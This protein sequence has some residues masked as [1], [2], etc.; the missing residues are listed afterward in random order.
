MLLLALLPGLVAC[1]PKPDTNGVCDGSDFVSADG[2]S[3]TCGDDEVCLDDAGCAACTP[4]LTS[5]YAGASPMVLETAPPGS[6]PGI[7][8]SR[9]VIIAT[10]DNIGG[11]ALAFDGPAE[12]LD[13]DGVVITGVAT[14]PATVFLRATSVGAATLTVSFAGGALPC[15]ED[16]TLELRGVAAAPLSGRPRDHAPGW[17]STESFMD[18]D[19]VYV[20]LDPMRF[21]DRVGLP[22]DVYIVA[23][24]TPDEWLADAALVDVT[25][26]V[27]AS[28]LTA[29]ALNITEAWPE[30]ALLDGG[31]GD[32][33]SARYDVVIDFGADGTLD[34]G[35]LVDGPGEDFGLSRIGDLSMDGPHRVDQGDVDGGTYLGERIYWPTDIATMGPRPLVVI[36][37]GNGHQHTWYDYIGEHLASWGFVVMAH[38]N[39]TEPGIQ[40]AS[41]S[42]LEN[43]DY[44]LSNLD[45]L[46]DGQLAGLVDSTRIGW[47]GHSRGGEGVVRAYDRLYDDDFVPV[48]YTTDDVRMLVTIA[49]TVFEEVNK[50]DPHDRPLLL[51]AGTADGDVNGGVDCDECDFFRLWE[52]DSGTKA[53][54]YIHGADHNDFNCCGIDDAIGPDPIGRD[55]AQI[56]A[57]GYFLA[58]SL[59]W[60]DDDPTVI[61]VFRRAHSGFLPTG[62]AE[63][64]VVATTF[65][66]AEST[67]AILDDFQEEED[68]AIASSG[69]AVTSTVEDVC[70]DQLNDADNTETWSTDDDDPDLMN[71][72]THAATYVDQAAGTTFSWS[73]A[74]ADPAWAVT[75]TP[76]L[77]DATGYNVLSVTF[78]QVPRAPITVALAAPL[79]F[80]VVL[81]DA[82][83]VEATVDIGD[84]GSA[85]VPYQ[86]TGTGDG[87]GWAAEFVTVRLPLAD[88]T[89][90]SK[91]DLSRLTSVKLVFG[92]EHGASIGAIGLDNVEFS[93]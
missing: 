78:A 35:D 62:H 86:R 40:T 16:A 60:L 53:A 41:T 77:Q 15:S 9:P 20:A 12:A 56:I 90:G 11:A 38:E 44:L 3:Q 27:D 59:T 82:D 26:A 73:E 28:T 33:A 50:S 48:A 37:H 79:T 1:H 61:D 89:I 42:T 81:A 65:R 55:E 22:Y 7:L 57:R 66:S 67:L 74:T 39:H 25:G 80:G 10:A 87:A 93:P 76:E 43:T 34:P 88:F 8:R 24:K 68:P 75:V 84:R 45:S 6:S 19:P 69:G 70:E 49:P 21:S 31:Q 36:S 18:T 23:H 85:P 4:T 92:A 63:G 83:G 51:I 47:I 58:I 52:A 30:P 72:M 2:S 5:T 17:E 13:A 32:G 54:T 14:L 29:G 46:L 91:L 71:G 64:D